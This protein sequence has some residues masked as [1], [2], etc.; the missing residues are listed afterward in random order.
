MGG[1][2]NRSAVS[3]RLLWTMMAALHDELNKLEVWQTSLEGEITNL[4]ST[5][6][7]AETE[8]QQWKRESQKKKRGKN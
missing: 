2:A 3:I 6:L 1:L 7:T 4:K 5:S 8:L